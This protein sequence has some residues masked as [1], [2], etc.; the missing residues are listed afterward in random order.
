MDLKLWLER[1]A[2]DFVATWQR[3]P[4]AIA[5]AALATIIFIGA[6]NNVDWLADEVWARAAL[7]LATGATL[8]VAGV[9]FR[10]SRPEAKAVGLLVGIGLPLLAVA[11]FQVTDSFWFVPWALPLIAILWLSVSPFTRIERGAAR[12]EQQNRF[13]WI[14]HQALATA[15]IAAGG[16]LVIAIGIVAIERSLEVLFGRS[17]ADIF[18]KF[19]LPVTGLFLTPVYWLSTLPRLSEFQ[20]GELDKPEFTSRAIGFLGQ[21][22]LVPLLL[23]YA[24]ILLAYIAQIVV[25]QRLPQGMIGWMVLGFVV[26]GAGT[27]LI[28]HP[29]FMRSRPLVRLF[30]R[31]WFWLTLLPLALFFFAVYVRID[32]YGLTPERIMLV[33]GGVWATLLAVIFLSGRGDIRVVPALAGI[34]L[35]L[36]SVGPWNVVHLPLS[37]QLSRLDALVTN[38]GADQSASPPRPDWSPAEIEEAR[39]IIDFLVSSRSGQQGVREVMGKYGV[40]WP[41]GQD[42]SYQVLEALGVLPD[43]AVAVS[44]TYLT[45]S[46]TPEVSVDVSATP[47]LLGSFKFLSSTPIMVGG[48]SLRIYD[49]YVVAMPADGSRAAEESVRANLSGWVAAQQDGTTIPDPAIDFTYAGL[50]YRF[51]A[52]TVQI[53]KRFYEDAPKIIEISGQLFGEAAAVQ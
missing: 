50:R 34:V 45:V 8:A 1:Q 43:P 52:E 17:S 46:R 5:L 53:I 36:L 14:N 47:V 15:A 20:A 49:E 38:A 33:A 22:V 23:I 18:Y 39:G 35:L 29:A 9:Y 13:W 26:A 37:Q 27:W 32:A 6:I 51:V 19:V 28:L 11:A 48:M 7:G 4:L 2:P 41:V 12:E 10:E 42:G 24:L 16:F 3:F 44:N 40:T 30:R 21:F 25:L 31:T